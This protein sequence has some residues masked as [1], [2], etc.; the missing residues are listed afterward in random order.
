M[1]LKV[2]ILKYEY[3]NQFRRNYIYIMDKLYLILQYVI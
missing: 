2:K 1:V 3:F